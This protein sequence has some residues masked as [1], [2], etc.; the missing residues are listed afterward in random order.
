MGGGGIGEGKEEE[1][2][3]EKEWQKHQRGKMERVL[4]TIPTDFI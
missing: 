2:R 3:G 4:G 1:R